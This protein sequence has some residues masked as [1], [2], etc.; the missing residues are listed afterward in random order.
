MRF[1]LCVCAHVVADTN[2]WRKVETT[3]DTLVPRV[4]H[5]AIVL[6]SRLYVFGGDNRVA[7]MEAITQGFP[8]VSGQYIVDMQFV[9]MGTT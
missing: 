6:G 2:E 1:P 3:G 9:D 8:I 5:A 7:N 4:L